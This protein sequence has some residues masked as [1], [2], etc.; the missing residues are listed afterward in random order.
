[1]PACRLYTCDGVGVGAPPYCIIATGA[2][3]PDVAEAPDGEAWAGGRCG[4]T[5]ACIDG[6]CGASA[7]YG[8][9]TY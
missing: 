7:T 3:P 8:G 9:W 1:M 4:A 5:A 6:E 2:P